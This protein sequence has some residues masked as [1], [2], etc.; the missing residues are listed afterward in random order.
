M[1]KI[2]QNIMVAEKTKLSKETIFVLIIHDVLLRV[3]F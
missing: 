3:A 2:L 1:G